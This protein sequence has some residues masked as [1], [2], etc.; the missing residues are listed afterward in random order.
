MSDTQTKTDDATPAAGSGQEQSE[1]KLFTQEEVNSFLATEKR[2]WAKKYAD[3]EDLK[4]KVAEFEAQKAS[5][6]HPRGCG[7]YTRRYAESIKTAGSS[8]RV[9]EPPN[10]G[11]PVNGVHSIIPAGGGTTKKARTRNDKAAS[12]PCKCGNH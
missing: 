3:Y 4:A 5:W 2:S 8:L 9:R 6:A 12:H 11:H 1:G 7:D 10:I